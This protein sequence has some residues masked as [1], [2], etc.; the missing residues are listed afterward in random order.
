MNWTLIGQ[1]GSIIV[2]VITTIVT[3]LNNRSNNKTVKELELTKQKFAQENE[4][5][6]RNQAMQDFKNKLISNFLGDL[7]AIL[8]QFSDI[9]LLKQAQ[10]SAG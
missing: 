1:L 5:L 4:K 10:K 6:K 3:F 9:T 2:A 7:S 8:N